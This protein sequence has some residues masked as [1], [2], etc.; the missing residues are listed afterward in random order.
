MSTGGEVCDTI[1]PL[2]SST[3]QLAC[4]PA[5][6]SKARVATRRGLRAAVMGL[7]FTGNTES[8]YQAPW[9]R[10]RHLRDQAVV[11]ADGVG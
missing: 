4:A 10:G 8:K 7:L 11:E 6:A 9:S 3:V 1:W 2:P 5:A